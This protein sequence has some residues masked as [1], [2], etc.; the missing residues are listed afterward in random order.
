MVCIFSQ[1][2]VYLLFLGFFYHL[3]GFCLALYGRRVKE[4]NQLWRSCSCNFTI[5][6]CLCV[7]RTDSDETIYN[8]KCSNPSQKVC[9]R[10]FSKVGQSELEFLKELVLQMYLNKVTLVEQWTLLSWT[11]NPSAL[12]R[13]ILR[14]ALSLMMLWHLLVVS[15]GFSR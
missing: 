7:Q 1:F 3:G 5:K 14:K 8:G 6:L 15:C 4:T 12:K 11:V 13:W 2:L 10:N 9:W